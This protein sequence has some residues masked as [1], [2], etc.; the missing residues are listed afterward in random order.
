MVDFGYALASE[1]A[2]MEADL[3]ILDKNEEKVR[4]IREY[5]ENALVIKNLDKASLLETGIQ[6]CDVADRLYRRADGYVYSDDPQSG[7]EWGYPG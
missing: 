4:E 5:T 1:L 3:L 7:V 6:N 2:A